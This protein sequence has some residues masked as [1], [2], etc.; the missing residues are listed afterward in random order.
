MKVK[1]AVVF[2]L[3]TTCLSFGQNSSLFNSYKVPKISINTLELEGNN[4]LNFL[5]NTYNHGNTNHD[6]LRVNLN[7]LHTFLFQSTM[8]ENFIYTNGWFNYSKTTLSQES[9][10]N[11]INERIN[12][13]ITVNSSNSWYLNNEK[14]MFLFLNPFLYI[15]D[16]RNTYTKDE[17]KQHTYSGT[18]G[19]GMGRIVNVR[20]VAQAYIISDELKC[21]LSDEKL[22][23]LAEIIEKAD[24]LEYYYNFKENAEIEMFKEIDALTGKPESE[25]KIRQIFNSAI[26]QTSIRRIGWRTKLGSRFTYSEQYFYYANINPGYNQIVRG[27]DLFASADYALPIGFDKQVMASAEYS[28]NLNDGFERMPQLKLMAE[29]MIDH[30]YLWA[31]QL[32]ISYNLAF[33]KQQDDSRNLWISLRTNLVLINKLTASARVEY[34]DSQYTSAYLQGWNPNILNWPSEK[35]FSF[36]LG[37]NYKIF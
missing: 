7:L 17:D 3:M 2:I 23:R 9:A 28:I 15:N 18:F 12:A 37:L 5:S 21:N 10:P 33:A 24:N 36:I 30:S 22:I 26:Y 14:G 8:S 32:D 6:E 34:N 19:L 20:S 27:T 13:S 25:S 16:N 11:S 4:L 1:Y 31:S 35:S 29:F